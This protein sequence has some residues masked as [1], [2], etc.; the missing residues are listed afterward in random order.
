MSL[1]TDEELGI[2]PAVFPCPYV[3]NFLSQREADELFDHFLKTDLCHLPNPWNPTQLLPTRSISY[4]NDPNSSQCF[5]GYVDPTRPK[6]LALA[7]EEEHCEGTIVHSS[8]A[9]EC[10][11]SLQRKLNDYLHTM[12]GY[13]KSHINYLSVIHYPDENAGINWHRHNEDD[14]C[15][16]PVLLIS[17]GEVRDFY[18]GEINKS[19]PP[20]PDKFWRQPMEHGSLLVMPD[21]MNYTHWHAILK[22]T[23]PNRNK[24]GVPNVKYGPRISINTKCLR[25]PKVFRVQER[26]PRWAV[27]VGCKKNQFPASIYANDWTP[28]LGHTNYISH[29]EAGFREYAEKKWLDPAFREQAIK[30]LRGKHL[31]CWNHGGGWCHANVWL[32]IVNRKP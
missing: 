16:S 13:E 14:G 22:N 2:E 11:W 3:P 19:K 1:F 26:H 21:A 25:P 7:E 6:H 17:T 29:S 4:V 24:F 31:L 10:I 18:L 20:S 32:E 27:Y 12:P 23:T 5:G 30:D 15:D 8:E 9:P 28:E